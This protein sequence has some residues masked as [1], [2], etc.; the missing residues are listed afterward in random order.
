MARRPRAFFEGLFHLCSHASDTRHLF[1]SDNDCRNFLDRLAATVERFELRIVAYVLLG[2]HYHAVFFTPD[3]RISTALQQLHTGYSRWHNRRRGRRAHLFRAHPFARQIES[4]DDLVG[5]CRY[6]AY[7]P[8]EAGLA[9]TP[10]A[11]PWSSAAASAGL[12]DACVPLDDGPLRGAF[13]G[14]PDWRRRYRGFLDDSRTA[15]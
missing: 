1:L 9:R 15:G 12:R 10:F 13:G 4:D 3:A 5:V 6:L 8:V 11:W 14:R 7:N 2:T